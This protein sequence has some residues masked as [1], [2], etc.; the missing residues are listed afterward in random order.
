MCVSILTSIGIAWDS[1]DTMLCVVKALVT[2][3]GSDSVG[4][5]VGSLGNCPSLKSH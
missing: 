4:S 3:I 1:S 2:C 5:T